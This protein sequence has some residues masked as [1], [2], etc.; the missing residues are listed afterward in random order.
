MLTQQNEALQLELKM[1]N[2]KLEQATTRSTA[3][4]ALQPHMYTPIPAASAVF[5]SGVPRAV[6]Q[7]GAAA[8]E[9]AAWG[10]Q[11]GGLGRSRSGVVEADEERDGAPLKRVARSALPGGGGNGEREGEGD[12]ERDGDGERESDGGSAENTADAG[13]D[14]SGRGLS[15]RFKG[16]RKGI[17][18]SVVVRGLCENVTEA[19]IL[20]AFREASVGGAAA[21]AL[22]HGIKSVKLLPLNRRCALRRR[23]APS[24]RETISCWCSSSRTSCSCRARYPGVGGLLAAALRKR[25]RTARAPRLPKRPSESRADGASGRLLARA[26]GL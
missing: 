7:T 26:P 8:A 25:V 20:S 13:A 10:G 3:A 17:A 2:Q 12:A 24:S 22:E 14:A 23:A 19:A 21:A 6:L 15:P 11:E 1:A 18:G 5:Q 4:A 9:A 16:G